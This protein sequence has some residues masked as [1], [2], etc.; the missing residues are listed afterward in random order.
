MLDKGLASIGSEH[1]QLNGSDVPYQNGTK[2]LNPSSIQR[3]ASS[4]CSLKA[5]QEH[6]GKIKRK[7]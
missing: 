5:P 4:I 7:N 6:Q 3:P 1:H 2:F